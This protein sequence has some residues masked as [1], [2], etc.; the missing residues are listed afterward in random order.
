MSNSIYYHYTSV[1]GCHGIIS[2]RRVWLTDYRFLNDRKELTQGLTSFLKHI[3]T[4]RRSSL[5]QAFLWHGKFNHHCVLSLSQSPRILSQWRA[6]AADGTGVALGLDENNLKRAGL[7]LVECRYENHDA[8]AKALVDKHETFIESVHQAKLAHETEN[9]FIAWVVGQQ[10]AFSAIVQDLI[11]LKN[12]AFSEEQEMRA[13]LSC[14][15]GQ[16]KARLSGQ[17][18]VPYLEAN[19]WRDEEALSKMTVVMPEIWLGPK[20]NEL[21]RIVLVAMNIGLRK[22]ERY[23]CGYV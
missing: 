2:S 18:I 13:V 14:Y 23:D 3:E 19:I 15:Q 16:T 4:D 8:F 9:E 7:A 6:Y 10:P 12:P 1:A 20:C 22:I 11:A 21:N 5:E 17:L